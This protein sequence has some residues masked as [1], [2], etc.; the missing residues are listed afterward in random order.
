MPKF[1]STSSKEEMVQTDFRFVKQ[2]WLQNGS[3][4]GV[5]TIELNQDGHKGHFMKEVNVHEARRISTASTEPNLPRSDTKFGKFYVG[6]S[7]T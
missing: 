4:V 7:V 6:Y 2:E 5:Y 3:V 1:C